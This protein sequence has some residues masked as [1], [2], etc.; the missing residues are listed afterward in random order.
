MVKSSKETVSDV[1]LSLE[2]S[3]NQCNCLDL[4]LKSRVRGDFQARFCERL[5]VK[6]PLPTRLQTVI[7]NKKLLGSYFL[8]TKIQNNE[9]NHLLSKRIWIIV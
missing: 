2:F 5:R 1:V 7:F 9:K 3:S 4:Y 6:L 8:I